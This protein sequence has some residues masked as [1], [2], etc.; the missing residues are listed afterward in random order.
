MDAVDFSSFQP[1]N[2]Y[3][4]VFTLPLEAAVVFSVTEWLPTTSPPLWPFDHEINLSPRQNTRHPASVALAIGAGILLP[5]AVA[6]AG[7]RSSSEIGAH[8]RG[9]VHNHLLTEMG[10]ISAKKLFGRHRPNYD[11]QKPGTTA[12]H[13]DHYSFWSGHAAH[14][15][16]LAGYSSR[17]LFDAA[18]SRIAWGGSVL[19]FSA[20]T[21]IATGRVLDNA[22]HVSD[23]VVGAAFGSAVSQFVYDSVEGGLATS[24][25][26]VPTQRGIS[27]GVNVSL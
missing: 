26:V 25:K 17:L 6:T 12:V 13:D 23:V 19:F 4:D 3:Q 9:L 21:W 20:A 22:H 11:L 5:S 15:F 1:G 2:F 10:T 7:A 24:W 16:A 14:A 8:A 18:P 27:I